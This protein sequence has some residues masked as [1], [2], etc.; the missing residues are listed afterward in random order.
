MDQENRLNDV[1]LSFGGMQQ[2]SVPDG[3][4]DGV[5]LR[6][7]EMAEAANARRRVALF[8]AIFVAGLGGGFGTIQ[9]PAQAEPTSYDLF[10]GA[11]LSPAVL[12]HVDS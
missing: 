12:L 2:G 9:T 6:A 8:A 4:M 7:G 11:D 3:F 5:W 10:A 1:L